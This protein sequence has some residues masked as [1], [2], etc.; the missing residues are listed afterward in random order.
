MAI[1]ASEVVV[2]AN[3]RVYVAPE[4]TAV[5]TSATAALPAS[6]V[7]VGY[8][9]EEGVTF[10]GGAEQE[11]INAW[12]SF[13][14][15]RKLITSRTAGVEF[16]LRQWNAP[17]LEFAFGGGQIVNAGGQS[18]YAA[19]TPDEVDIR[20]LIVEWEDGA[21][22]YRLVIPR[23]QVSGEVETQLQRTSAADLPIAFSAV[24]DTDPLPLTTPTAGELATQAWYLVTDT[25]Q[26]LT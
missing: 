18:Y 12:Q 25:S 17:N 21:E 3:G 10:T 20:A 5:P 1:D 11:D 9:S 13:Y 14:P 4:D 19:P 15:I 24:P 16:V 22:T 8:I 23:G 26:F 6:W 2:G 7:N